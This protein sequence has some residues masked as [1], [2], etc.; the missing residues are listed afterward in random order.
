MKEL[1]PPSLIKLAENCPVPLYV[2][3]GS[4]RN[5]LAQ[6]S[7][8]S[9]DWDIC[10]P[11]LAET[12]FPI[13]E[14]SGFSVK[15]VYKH[16]GTVK[17]QD[18]NGID[19]EYTCFRSD[20]YVRGTHVPIEIYF[21]ED[22]NA[23]AKRR[24]F[25]AN[26]VYYDIKSEKFIDPLNGIE[27]ISK[28]RLTTVDRAEKVFGEDG[29]RLLRLARQA[30][31]LGFSP[32]EECLA[33]AKQ[34]ADLINDISAERIYKEL[35]LL[36]FADS[37]YGVTDGHYRGLKILEETNVLSHVLPELALGKG[38]L[39]RADFH[40]HDVLEHS[41]RAVLYAAPNVRLAALL[42]DVGKPYCMQTYGNAHAH[43]IEG[44]RITREILT[45]LKAPKKTVERVCKLV[46]YHMYD[47]DCKTGENKLRKFFVSNFDL[48][49]DLLFLKQA[50]FT[51]CKDDTMVAPTCKKWK[52]LLSKMQEE[53]VPFSVKDLALSGKDLLEI[54][55]P[56]QIATTLKELLLH[57]AVHPNENKKER[58]LK[59][60][61]RR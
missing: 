19:Y 25:T 15:N 4:V 33:G 23:D 16:T 61:R 39:Q 48:L 52:N 6:L 51:A 59:L 47:F 29:L 35:S 49:E 13:A 41:L 18:E 42:H 27:A 53:N 26:A 34:H 21:T 11:M 54:L 10:S 36:L 40:D 50:D 1:L 20:K 14:K 56:E 55:P 44:E 32:D 7:S 38:M 5:Y 37:A 9:V 24:D 58:L 45:R 28:K 2:V 17:F 57:V 8:S 31:Q 22:M 12:F 3:G 43:P 60:A 30:G 46:K